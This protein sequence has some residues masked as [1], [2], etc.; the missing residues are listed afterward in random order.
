MNQRP[1]KSAVPYLPGKETQIGALS[2]HQTPL[3]LS[4][5]FKSDRPHFSKQLRTKWQV[6]RRS[7]V[8]KCGDGGS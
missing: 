1:N 8:N 6:H 7:A 4:L 2:T 3:P 5:L